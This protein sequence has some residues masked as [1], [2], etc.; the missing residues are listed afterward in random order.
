MTGTVLITGAARRV[1]AAIARALAAEGW[2]GVVHYH[3]SA[4]DARALATD[5]RD[6]AVYYFGSGQNNT[7]VFRI[8][9]WD[10]WARRRG[11]TR[12]TRTRGRRGVGAFLHRMARRL[13]LDVARGRRLCRVRRDRHDH[14]FRLGDADLARRDT[15]RLPG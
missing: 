3:H 6:G 2:R 11:T 13:F 15:H 5:P 12:R 7:P 14:A 10:G 9:G 8:T 1:G 4:D